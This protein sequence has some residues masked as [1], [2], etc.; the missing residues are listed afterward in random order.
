L[1]LRWATLGT[2]CGLALTVKLSLIIPVAAVSA[3]CLI[4]V[5]RVR[6]WVSLIV[7]VFYF[8]CML[9]TGVIV[10][11]PV[12]WNIVTYAK[13]FV[14]TPAYLLQNTGLLT[15]V[16]IFIE[17]TARANSLTGVAYVIGILIS[18][19]TPAV[20]AWIALRNKDLRPTL[21]PKLA[22]LVVLM[23]GLYMTITTLTKGYPAL[24]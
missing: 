12:L 2:L 23:V 13:F 20:G 14:A 22:I 6:N 11:F 17:T 1:I 5:F 16:M 24:H 19:A 9:I 15:R 18:A 4:G 21:L 8:A 7:A 10:I 3:A